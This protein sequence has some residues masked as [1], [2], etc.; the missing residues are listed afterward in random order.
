VSGDRVWLLEVS[1]GGRE[2]RLSTRP[3]IVDGKAYEGTL[4]RVEL[5][6]TLDGIGRMPSEREAQISLVPGAS[7]SSYGQFAG[8]ATLRLWR[9]SGP[10]RV[11]IIGNMRATEVSGPTEPVSFTLAAEPYADQGSTHDPRDQ[12]TSATWPL[13]RDGDEGAWYARIFGT[14]GRFVF[15][16]S[17]RTDETVRL[18]VI[19]TEGTGTHPDRALRLLLCD[20][21][22]HEGPDD[23]SVVAIQQNGTSVSDIFGPLGSRPAAVKIAAPDGRE[24]WALDCSGSSAA[25]RSATQ[26]YGVVLS[27]QAIAYPQAAVSPV[28]TTGQLLE[29]LARESGIQIDAGEWAR[30]AETLPYRVGL[31]VREPTPPMDIALDIMESL[32]VALYSTPSGLGI[33]RWPYDATRADAVGWL[34]EAVNCSRLSGVRLSREAGD[35]A[36]AVIVEYGYAEIYDTYGDSLALSQDVYEAASDDKVSSDVWAA[37]ADQTGTVR[38]VQ[39]PWLVDDRGA[40]EIARWVM[41]RSSLGAREIDLMVDADIADT[42][43]L[44]SVVL[45][46]IPSCGLDDAVAIV[47]G[48]TLTDSSAWPMRLVLLSPVGLD[49][50]QRPPGASTEAP[51]VDPPPPQQ[52]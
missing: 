10:G 18:P 12:V 26:F 21:A 1:L 17:A 39:A 42:L 46:L 14:P 40:L 29:T 19:V 32:P 50:Q 41:R 49:V 8:R 5:R 33:V 9:G 44:G 20:A 43:L 35:G 51:P 30:V 47:A 36:S 15:R 37:T 31:V 23:V 4:D 25:F 7:L 11:E 2:L 6:E 24:V 34:V 38:T 3:V 48:R 52:G 16:G 28:R 27:D 45:V 22:N 13:A